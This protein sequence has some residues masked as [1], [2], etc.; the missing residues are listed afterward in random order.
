ME[1]LKID[2]TNKTIDDETVGACSNDSLELIGALTPAAEILKSGGTVAFPTETV[3]GLGANALDQKAIQKIYEAKGRPS[4]NPLIIHIASIEM[5]EDLVEAISS[6]AQKLIDAFWPGPLTLIFKKSTLVPDVVTAGLDSVAVRMPSNEIAKTLIALSE[7]PIAAPSANLSGKPSP[8]TGAH[9]VADLDGRVDAIVL[10]DQTEVGLESTVLDTTGDVPMILR[11]G[12]ITKEMVIE[13]CGACDVDQAISSKDSNLVPKAPGMKYRHYAPEAEVEVLLGDNIGIVKRIEA[14][15][16]EA[17]AGDY[18]LGLLLFE[19]DLL[20]LKNLLSH[21]IL[22]HDHIVIFSQGSAKTPEVF[23]NRLFRD[24]RS[25]DAFSCKRV[26]VHGVEDNG[27]GSAIM[28][29]LNKAANGLVTR[30]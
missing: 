23:A 28:N 15:I 1:T 25:S 18:K 26:L 17:V 16:K 9:V 7:L 4:D 14:E 13:I 22:S 30:I 12:A 11:P 27:I 21:D 20:V 24:L 10:G 29:R 6:H 3:Y 2:I 8:T 19:E 5:L